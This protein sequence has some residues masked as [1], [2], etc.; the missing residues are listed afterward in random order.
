[1]NI[2]FMLGRS[3]ARQEIGFQLERQGF[4]FGKEEKVLLTF[5]HEPLSPKRDSRNEIWSADIFLCYATKKRLRNGHDYLLTRSDSLECPGWHVKNRNR[6]HI[7]I[8]VEHSSR[9]RIISRW[10][11]GLLGP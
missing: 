11:Q 4:V 10:R 6:L 1:M 7:D 8:A 9:H 3:L 2:S 5:P